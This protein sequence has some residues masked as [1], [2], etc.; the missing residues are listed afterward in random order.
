MECSPGSGEQVSGR[1]V[2]QV[3][4][5]LNGNPTSSLPMIRPMASRAPLVS[6]RRRRRASES[7][8]GLL[9]RALE[10]GRPADRIG[11]ERSEAEVSLQEEVELEAELLDICSS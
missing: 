7:L 4:G 9:R 5:M 6:R 3:S 10:A 2:G 11:S 8:T 1:A